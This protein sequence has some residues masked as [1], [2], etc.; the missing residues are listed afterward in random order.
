MIFPDASGKR[1]HTFDAYLKETFGHKCVKIPLDGG[2]TCPNRDGAKGTGGCAFCSGGGAEDP[3]LTDGSREHP[4]KRELREQYTRGRARLFGKWGDLPCIASFSSYTSTYAP[5]GRLRA[6]YDEALSF[7]GV[8]G[9][10]VSTRPDALPEDVLDLLSDYARRT[11]LTV[12]LGLQTVNDC[13]ARLM[14]RC[15]PFSTF[16]AAFR[17]LRARGIRICVH[18][19]NGLPGE[20]RED[21]MKSARVLAALAPDGVK[22]HEL[23][24]RRGSAL[25][26]AYRRAPF[27]LLSRGEYVGIVADQIAL[28]PPSVVIERVTGDP[29]SGALIAP[30]WAADKK[31][32]LALLDQTL[33]KRGVYQGFCY[34][35][36]NFD[37]SFLDFDE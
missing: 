4:V 14:N 24:V 34:N 22:F 20:T 25:E 17:A 7:S 18:L 15:Y 29:L 12:E 28:L 35:C 19:I 11:A 30:D 5:P 26:E 3:A 16:L 36:T 31:K 27:A 33:A 2:F 8:V 6:L 13:T 10:T 37:A 9:L 32:T 23:Y 1:Y 21:M